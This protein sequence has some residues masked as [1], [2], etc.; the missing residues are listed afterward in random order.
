M[1]FALEGFLMSTAALSET[2]HRDA[3]AL[4]TGEPYLHRDGAKKR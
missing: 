2:S 4:S 3:E 1:I